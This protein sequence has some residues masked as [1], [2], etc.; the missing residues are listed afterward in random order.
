MK[1]EQMANVWKSEP[2]SKLIDNIPHS[3][4]YDSD[5]DS[6]QTFIIFVLLSEL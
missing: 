3:N 6:D 2:K 5:T 4:C 1:N